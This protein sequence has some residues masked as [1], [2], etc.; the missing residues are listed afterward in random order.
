MYISPPYTTVKPVTVQ[1]SP[2]DPVGVVR[3]STAASDAV[4]RVFPVAV[5]VP[6]VFV[7]AAYA[8]SVLSMSVDD[9]PV[10]VNMVVVGTLLPLTAVYAPVTFEQ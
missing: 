2:P 9:S 5:N 3:C 6:P 10:P 8:I 4:V 1:P 7:Q